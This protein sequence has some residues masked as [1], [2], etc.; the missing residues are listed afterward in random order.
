M[1][2]N[3]EKLNA[4]VGVIQKTLIDLH[5]KD[6]TTQTYKELNT[7][8]LSD[9]HMSMLR[10][11]FESDT[12]SKAQNKYATKLVFRL[13]SQLVERQAAAIASSQRVTANACHTSE[14]QCTLT[15][16]AKAKIR[17]VAGACL[18]TITGRLRVKAVANITGSSNKASRRAAYKKHM[19]LSKFRT[20][21]VDTVANTTIHE[22]LSE[23][24]AKQGST[25]G[26]YH[27]SDETYNFF[28]HLNAKAYHLLC[29][30]TFDVEGEN[31]FIKCR[32]DIVN[33]TPLN[34]VWSSL[35]LTEDIDE[36]HNDLQER[37]CHELFAMV[38]EHFLRI[39]FVDA[40]HRLKESIPK[41]KKMAL[42]AKV[43]GATKECA[44]KKR[45]HSN[46]AEGEYLCP[47]CKKVCPDNPQTP[48]D[49]SIGCDT[50]NRWYHQNCQGVV[51]ST[52]LKVW[53]CSA[54]KQIK[55]RH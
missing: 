50:C 18:S 29:K 11:L 42:R 43:Q 23:I 32:E 39:Q 47:T 25:R 20:S 14:Q 36:V 8:L 10:D 19:L 48:S 34:Q 3:A 13:D 31:A 24:D 15:D 1:T 12:I 26:L 37:M 51:D 54:C 28:V 53:K 7:F 9:S 45:Q 16:A 27:M 38:S 30:D 21:E 4:H 33:D 2:I 40:L 35:L 52:K 55:R 41:K 17:Y 49:F 6:A 44:F 22:S 46:E 5:T